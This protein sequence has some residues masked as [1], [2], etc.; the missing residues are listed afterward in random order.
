MPRNRRKF[1]GEQWLTLPALTC[2]WLLKPVMMSDLFAKYQFGTMFITDGKASRF[3][4]ILPIIPDPNNGNSHKEW[5][6]LDYKT[7][8]PD[9]L[10]QSL[11]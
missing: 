10:N 8:R 7:L 3:R 11:H 9:L 4:D 6:I 2:K 1:T 5:T